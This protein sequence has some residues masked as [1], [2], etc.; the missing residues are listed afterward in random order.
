MLTY[1]ISCVI[2][3]IRSNCSQL[4]NEINRGYSMKFRINMPNGKIFIFTIILFCIGVFNSVYNFYGCKEFYM[5]SIIIGFIPFTVLIIRNT[6]AQSKKNIKYYSIV[7]PTLIGVF[8][9]IMFLN[10]IVIKILD[11]NYINT[12]VGNYQKFLRLNN[13]SNNK[14]IKHFP[15]EVPENANKIEFREE[16]GFTKKFSLSYILEPEQ[17][18]LVESNANKREHKEIIKNYEQSMETMQ[19]F[20]IP[21]EV[22]RILEIKDNEEKTANFKIYL[23]ETTDVEY[24]THGYSYGVGINF[25]NNRVIY[26]SNKW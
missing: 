14:Y 13:Y 3:N 1:G 26:F 11:L 15:K 4:N 9:A 16:D 23:I 7:T 18:K 19:Q 8:I 24:L 25:N 6:I 20:N 12:D 21:K 2:I 17:I 22:L 5:L 10:V